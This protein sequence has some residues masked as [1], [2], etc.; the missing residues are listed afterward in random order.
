MADFSSRFIRLPAWQ[1]APHTP[2]SP[3]PRAARAVLSDLRDF[4]S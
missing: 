2:E 4:S 1:D 3:E